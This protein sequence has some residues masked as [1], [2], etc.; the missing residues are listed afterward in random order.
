M[1]VLIVYGTSEGQ[2]R[3]IAGAMA[4]ALT[5]LGHEAHGIDVADGTAASRLA[6]VGAVIVAASI[7]IGRYQR[8]VIRFVREHREPIAARPNLFV[9]VS[10]AAAGTDPTDR[11]GIAA[12]AAKFGVETG[13]RPDEI[14]HVAGAF[15]FS[16]YG[17][18]KRL[19]MRRI[20]R[21]KR[22]AIDPHGDTELT[23]WAAL[24]QATEAF[25][26]RAAAATRRAAGPGLP[27]AAPAAGAT[28]T[29]GA[30]SGPEAA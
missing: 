2:T 24:R 12:C 5:R 8:A 27:A 16:R 23:D 28:A 7:H 15:R 26:A 10:L 18:F 9:S 11:A 1:R 3:K 4:T 21:R 29:G 25:A 22:V 17:F 20:A 14:V 30:A 13:W 6:G 19:L